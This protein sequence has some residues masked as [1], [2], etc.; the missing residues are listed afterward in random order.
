[1]SE[2]EYQEWVI[3]PTKE[4]VDAV[5]SAHPS[6]PIIGFPRGSSGACYAAYEKEAGVDAI[7]IDVETSLSWA[8]DTLKKPLQ[9][10]LDPLV[11]ANDKQASIAETKRILETASGK[12]FIF[13]LGHG[14]LPQ[15]PL[16]TVAAVC[17][18]IRG[19][20]P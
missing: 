18:T 12:P 17:E 19:S 5:R 11:L 14:I 1:L 3:A 16:E 13:N 4:L 8:F 9:G 7:G 10:N 6:V 15:T 20:A 2:K